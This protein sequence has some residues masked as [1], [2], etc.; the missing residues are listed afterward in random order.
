MLAKAGMPVWLASAAA[1]VLGALFG[2]LNGALVAYAGPRL[3]RRGF[4]GGLVYRVCRLLSDEWQASGRFDS[5]Q[6]RD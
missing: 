6:I 4:S 1:C 3:A 2:S 5:P